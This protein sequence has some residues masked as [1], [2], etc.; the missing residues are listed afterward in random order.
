M[1]AGLTAAPSSTALFLCPPEDAHF[2]ALCKIRGDARIQ[3]MLMTASVTADPD[4]VRQW[5]ARRL[6]E[7]DGAFRVVT[8]ECGSALGFVQVARVYRYSGFGYGGLA[9]LPDVQRRGVG[10]RALELL[11]SLAREELGL[12]KLIAEIGADN[13]ASLHLHRGCGYHE[14]GLLRRHYRDAA[15][16]LHD[17]VL[18]ERFLEDGA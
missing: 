15:G 13:A 11:I 12:R 10:Q 6:A 5:I 3:A 2:D 1:P 17:V 18:M 16:D 4:S 7:P 8:D 14:A 9:L